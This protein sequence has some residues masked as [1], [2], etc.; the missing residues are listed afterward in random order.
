ML[1]NDSSLDY[2]GKSTYLPV[3]APTEVALITAGIKAGLSVSELNKSHPRL[4]S[5]PFESEHKFM[6]CGV[7]DITGSFHPNALLCLLMTLPFPQA[8]VHSPLV[9]GGKR[10]LFVKGAPDRV[11][12]FCAEQPKGDSSLH[13]GAGPSDPLD[14]NYWSDA[15]VE[16][17]CCIKP[18]L[19]VFCQLFVLLLA[20][21]A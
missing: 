15:Q 4:A 19:F 21:A 1:C 2:D 18:Q 9:P 7:C 10:I 12:P 11:I 16:K 6:V 3:G 14:I 20:L 13:L 17:G 5:V 8:T